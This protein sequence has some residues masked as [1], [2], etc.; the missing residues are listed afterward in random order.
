[1]TEAK[2]RRANEIDTA[3]ELASLRAQRAALIEQQTA[4]AE[5]LKSISA[6]GFD[7]ARVLQ[8]VTEHARPPSSPRAWDS[9]YSRG[10]R[11][12]L[13]PTVSSRCALLPALLSTE[14]AGACPRHGEWLLARRYQWGA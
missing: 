13:R 7:L 10:I 8:T 14:S 5:V 6:S 4:V 3:A 12:L 1:L 11:V 9:W 2:A